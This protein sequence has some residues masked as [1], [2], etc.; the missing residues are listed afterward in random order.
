MATPTTVTWARDPHTAA[1]H[2]L[3]RRY[4][5]AWFPIMAKQFREKGFTY[6]DGFA[7]PGEYTNSQ[8]SSPLVALE[9]ALRS[10]VTQYNTP[11]RVVLLEADP[12]RAN[13][14]AQVVSARFPVIGMQPTLRLILKNGSCA[15]D[16][17]SELTAC[18]AWTGPVF[19][20]L[21]GWGVDTPFD[22]VARIAKQP[23]SEVLVTFKDSWFTRFATIDDVEAGD[24]VFGDK[25]WRVVTDLPTSDKKAFLVS[26]Y[27][28]RLASVGL[29]HTLTFEM[30]DEGGHSLFLVFGT[31]SKHGVEKM[32]DALWSVDPVGGGRFRDPSDPDQL[33][34]DIDHPDF[35][36]LERSVVSWLTG[37]PMSLEQLG[38]HAQ[39][40][41]IYKASHVKDV[42]DSLETRTVVRKTSNGRSHAERIYSLTN[43]G[44]PLVSALF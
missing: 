43:D 24:R 1:K 21:D 15:T 26:Q 38:E 8:E 20:N 42:V 39:E 28:S 18:G 30:L 16:L 5:Q 4:L 34:F 35:H 14:L 7:G 19:A 13:R 3:L 44:H 12:R 17:I 6:A 25:A 2:R 22:V 36:P 31:A 29:T 23:S 27:R 37:G 33:S 11:C 40:H 10:E 41:T 32:K 9:Q